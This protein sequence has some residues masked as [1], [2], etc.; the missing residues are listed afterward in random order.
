MLTM[1]DVV[2]L[3]RKYGEGG[4]T[5]DSCG[6]VRDGARRCPLEAAAWQEPFTIRSRADVR[7][8]ADLLSADVVACLQLYQAADHLGDTTVDPGARAALAKLLEPAPWLLGVGR[9]AAGRASTAWRVDGA[10]A[11]IKARRAVGFTDPR[12]GILNLP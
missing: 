5:H 4:W 7:L 10:S 2:E 9:L 8:V 6:R 12:A 3:A 11:Q 1:A